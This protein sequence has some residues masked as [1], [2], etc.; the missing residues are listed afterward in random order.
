MEP[1]MRPRAF[2]SAI[3]GLVLLSWLAV[4]G[5]QADLVVIDRI[6]REAFERSQVMEHLRYLTDVHGPR[7]T[8]SPQFDEAAAWAIGRLKEYGL[9]N[10]HL[11][12]WGPFGRSWSVAGYAVEQVEPRYALLHAAPLAWSASTK[13]AVMG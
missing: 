2:I 8:G 10:A 1:S 5:Q 7:L 11:D 6:K 3:A 12:R 4:D 13:G 9:V